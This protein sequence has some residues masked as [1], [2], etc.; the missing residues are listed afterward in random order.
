MMESLHPR[1][2]A[3]ADALRNLGAL[4]DEHGLESISVVE[5]DEELVARGLYAG[6]RNFEQLSVDDSRAERPRTDGRYT[7]ILTA[8]GRWLDRRGASD[9]M[10]TEGEQYLAVGGRAPIPTSAEGY[11]MG[12]FEELLVPEEIE[13]LAKSGTAS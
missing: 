8:L 6:T 10:I 4:L 5:V 13:A 2:L 3:Y 11:I 9:V 7:Q 12:P 1:K